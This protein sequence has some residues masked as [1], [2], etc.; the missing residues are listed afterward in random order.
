MEIR[1][2]D[3]LLTVESVGR[4]A[5]NR[6]VT[7]ST[8]VGGVVKDY[9]ADV[10]DRVKTEQPLV[11]IDPLDYRLALREAQA[12]LAAAQARLEAATKAYARS[13]ALLPQKAISP[14]TFDKYEAEYKSHEAALSQIKA[15]VDIAEAREKKTRISAPF[16]GI[17]ARRLVE[18]GQTVGV[19]TPVMALVDLDAIRVRIHTAECDYVNVSR[20]DLVRVTVEAFPQK[21][22]EGR[23]DRIGVKADERTNTFDV[24]ILIDNPDLLL[25][26][27]LTAR[28]RITT[29]VLPDT[30][31]IPQSTVLYREDRREV[32]VVG[33]GNTAELR[34]IQL[35][36][37]EGPFIQVL[38]GLKPG[39][40]L[41]V[42]GGQYLK[43]GDK[44]TISHQE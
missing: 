14:D 12:S 33:E 27:G 43:P 32:F 26:P 44:I 28:V 16:P 15:M 34:P 9:F 1:S 11:S 24:E 42:A 21:T 5:A 31:L 41:V 38:K 2:Q 39:E 4:V 29:G 40:R 37:T 23:I 18:K 7:L 20:D 22:F 25:K 10:G 6:E 8:E 19:G 17:V 35:G 13:K 30:I 3:L 36:R